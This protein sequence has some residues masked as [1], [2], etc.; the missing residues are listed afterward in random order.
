MKKNDKKLLRE[1][2]R[3]R[4]AGCG[5][6][7]L[8]PFWNN[9]HLP[10]H[11]W[12][13]Y[14]QDA[15]GAAIIANGKKFDL[16][17]G[18]IYLLPPHNDLVSCCTGNPKQLYFHFET[19]LYSGSSSHLCNAVEITPELQVL[20]EEL[21]KLVPGTELKSSNRQI[22]LATALTSLALSK[23]PEEA[24][25]RLQPDMRIARICDVLRSHM[26]EE[27]D[28]DGLAAKAKMTKRTFL[29]RFTAFTGSTPHQYLLNV[30]YMQAAQL[31]EEGETSIDE[32]CE[33]I[34]VN[35]RFHFSRMFRKIFG[36]PPAKYRELH[37]M[38]KVSSEKEVSG[39]HSAGIGIQLSPE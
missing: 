37:Q 12:R 27:L 8:G 15:P 34:G 36:T 2:F 4:I 19:T 29:R 24:L 38:E 26:T 11:F 5:Q 6:V 30:R 22:L 20:L 10:A 25:T 21:R 18:Y 23:L 31:L 9:R 39:S 16:L 28:L 13:L 3:F 14:C 32:I 33:L 17:P 35:D 1:S 7:R